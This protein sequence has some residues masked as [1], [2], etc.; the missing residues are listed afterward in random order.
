MLDKLLTHKISIP[1]W[2]LLIASIIFY[3]TWE[4][5]WYTQVGLL[6]IKWH[7]H[8]MPYLIL[9][10]LFVLVTQLP[11]NKQRFVNLQLLAT[12]VIATLCL[13]ELVLQITGF[14]K[15]Y[16]EK[17]G[18][19]YQ[20]VFNQKGWDSTRTYPPNS[21]HYLSS[22]E[23]HYLRNVNSL[24]LSDYAFLKQSDKILIQ[25]YGDSFT[26]GDGAP[27]DS[28]YPALLRNLVG[29][30]FQIQNFGICGND[31]GFYP[32][33]MARIGANFKPNLIILC[34]GT[35]DFMADFLSR[36]GLE[37]YTLNGWKSRKGPWWELIYG[38]SY[39]ARPIFNALG[40]RYENFFFNQTQMQEELKR[41]ELKWNETFEEIFSIARKNQIKVLVLKKPERSEVVLNQYQYNMSFFDSLLLQNSDIKHFDLLP[42]Y[43]N[44]VG[45]ISQE[46]TAPYYWEKDG[47]HNSNGYW[48]MAKG[49]LSGLKEN[50]PQWFSKP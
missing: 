36:G 44:N 41:L 33:Q 46:T 15:T 45:L 17:R 23:F 38:T 32:A 40:F 35:G 1:V 11:A 7:T 6:F 25:T 26:E 43:R 8:Y 34:Y 2:L 10:G 9:W 20:S 39:L 12:T 18:G 4:W 16:T 30:N 47:H 42:Y 19:I 28:S 29:S 48:V 31:P 13:T 24:G 27:Q 14:T 5:Y 21:E 50:Y 37:R 3:I 49:V 22:P